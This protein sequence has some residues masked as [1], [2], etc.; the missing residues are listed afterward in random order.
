MNGQERTTRVLAFDFGASSGRAILG[1][2]QNGKLTMQEVSRFENDPVRV[3]DTL[4]WDVLRLYHHIQQALVQAHK[5][6]GYDSVG[7]DTWGV[8]FGLLS[9]WGEL[10]ENPVHYR[11]S[12]ADDVSRRVQRQLGADV[13]YQ[14]TG[15]QFMPF[16]TLFQLCAVRE[17][18]PALLDNADKMLLMPDLFNYFLT[19]NMVTERTIASTSQLVTPGARD[20]NHALLEELGIP[21]RLFAPLVSPGTRVGML[22][23]RLCQ[24]LGIPARPVVAVASHDTASA[25]AA[26]PTDEKNFAFLSSGTWS[27]LGAELDEPVVT[28]TSQRYNLTNEVGYDDTVRFINN[29]CGLWLIQE[30]RRQLRREGREYSYAQ[31]EELAMQEPP[32]AFLIDP[33]APEFA[34]PGD[35]PARIR[36]YC[37][38]SGQPVPGSDAQVVRCIYDSLALKYTAA[39]ERL[40]SCTGRAYATLHMVG[41]GIQAQ[42]LC[43][44]TADASGRKVIAG[45]VEATAA[46]NMAVQL[47]AQRALCDLAQARDVI[48]ASLETKEYLPDQ[49]ARAQWRAAY[50]HYRRHILHDET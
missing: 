38:Q 44:M 14:R 35:M 42:L 10:M 33:D 50:T 27:L 12:R 21:A 9:P 19:G 39:L 32:F 13:L 6:G 29:L 36:A 16:N 37:R 18:T 43:Q 30:T 34:P 7:I 24:E 47:I 3:G 25:V 8:D 4:R 45:P 31:L 20:W 28:P 5:M 1:S 26:V 41:G 49:A 2:L 22:R 46:G 40:S 17:Q 11:D 48:A 15:I 23:D